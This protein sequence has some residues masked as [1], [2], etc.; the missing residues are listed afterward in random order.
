MLAGRRGAVVSALAAPF[1]PVPTAKTLLSGV[2][3]VEEIAWLTADEAIV[4]WYFDE[5]PHISVA[6]TVE[7]EP[8]DRSVGI[9]ESYFT[10]DGDAP[11]S[12]LDRVAEEAADR[13]IE[14]F[15]ERESA[16]DEDRDDY[17]Y[18]DEAYF[19]GGDL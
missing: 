11:D 17:R 6:V 16:Y 19:A 12:I 18:A 7:F 3:L 13:A 8:R 15:E 1:L 4:T 14:R 5:G 9:N 10:A 2:P